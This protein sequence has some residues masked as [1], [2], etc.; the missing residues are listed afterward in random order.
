[1]FNA[2][3]KNTMDP[4]VYTIAEFNRTHRIG[5]SKFYTL[6]K[7]GL[8]PRVVDLNGK[9]VIYGEDAAAWRRKMAELSA[10]KG[11]NA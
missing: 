10:A 8:A 9:K 1:M 7:E 6:K 5:H 4:L 11:A 2:I 3:R